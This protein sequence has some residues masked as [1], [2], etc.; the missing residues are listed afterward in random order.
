MSC[1]RFVRCQISVLFG[2]VFGAVS[3]CADSITLNPVA[4]TALHELYSD[5]NFGGVTDLPAGG[6]N[7]PGFQTR[8]LFRFDLAAIPTNATITSVTL[9][10]TV[11][12]VPDS[13]PENSTFGLH[14]LLQ[15]WGE[16]NKG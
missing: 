10:L 7:L 8:A 3:L 9:A 6:I 15:S 13:F 16:G 12:R 5:N 4:D 14:R 2:G 11:T 1:S